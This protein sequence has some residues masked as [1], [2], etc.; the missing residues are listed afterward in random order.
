MKKKK[1]IK[2]II[3]E[4][5]ETEQQMLNIIKHDELTITDYLKIKEIYDKS[6]TLHSVLELYFNYRYRGVYQAHLS[7]IEA[8]LITIQRKLV[9]RFK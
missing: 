3:T 2:N 4:I 9:E 1:I 7:M 5:E 8:Y 6:I